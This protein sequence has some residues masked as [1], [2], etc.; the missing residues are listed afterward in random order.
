M[1]A[2]AAR[3]CVTTPGLSTLTL[4]TQPCSRALGI[5]L[6]HSRGILAYALGSSLAFPRP[7][8]RALP[9]PSPNSN[10]RLLINEYR[11]LS[12]RPLLSSFPYCSIYCTPIETV[13]IQLPAS[14]PC[15]RLHLRRR[16]PRVVEAL[17]RRRLLLGVSRHGRPLEEQEEYVD[18]R[19][20]RSSCVELTQPQGCTSLRHLQGKGTEEDR[21]QRSIRASCRESVGRAGPVSVRRCSTC[22]RLTESPRGSRSA[23]AR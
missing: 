23:C 15:R 3:A 11:R 10:T 22:P 7:P 14:L 19:P 13:Y 1:P 8:F 4:T 2:P 16:R 9:T 12:R 5:K 6:H 20:S 18:A 21:Y 17:P